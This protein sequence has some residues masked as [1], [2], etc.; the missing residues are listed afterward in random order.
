MGVAQIYLDLTIEERPL[1]LCNRSAQWG[2]WESLLRWEGACNRD[3]Q[4][5]RVG[6]MPFQPRPKQ[7]PRKAVN[8]NKHFVR[9][10]EFSDKRT[11]GGP[12][13]SR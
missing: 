7:Y 13:G 3:V 9:N 2:I 6:G 1:S 12:V 11:A 8:V 5:K 10:R 4:L